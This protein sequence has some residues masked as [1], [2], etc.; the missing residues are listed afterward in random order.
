MENNKYNFIRTSFSDTAKEL[1]DMG[2]ELVSKSGNV[3][4]FYNKGTEYL[5]FFDKKKIVPT[6][7]LHV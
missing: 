2:F 1:I 3:Y 7:I 5:K 4:T 6:N